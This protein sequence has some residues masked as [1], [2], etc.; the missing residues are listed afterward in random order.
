MLRLISTSSVSTS[1]SVMYVFCMSLQRF[2]LLTFSQKVSLLR[3]SWI[4][5]TIWMSMTLQL[6]R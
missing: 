4:S 5:D 1:P 3:C 2:S 6:W